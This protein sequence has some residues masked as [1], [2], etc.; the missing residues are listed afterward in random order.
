VGSWH[1]SD[2]KLEERFFQNQTAFKELLREV[3][4]D[5][6]L[7]SISATHVWYH[8]VLV[9]GQDA[10][11]DLNKSG[12]TKARWEM[13][14]HMMDRLGIVMLA[15]SDKEVVFKVDLG[16]ITNGDSEKGYV[17][18]LSPPS[19][20]RKE[21]LDGYRLSKEDVDEHGNAYVYKPLCGHWYLFLYVNG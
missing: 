11:S 3:R 4:A 21:S 18:S 5:S 10:L 6:E 13:Y 15:Q 12:F 17:Y 7:E 1:P 2:S 8:D 19:S 16:K 9:Q 20:H 14:I